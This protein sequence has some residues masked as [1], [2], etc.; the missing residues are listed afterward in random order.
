MKRILVI[1]MGI[2]FL[3]STIFMAI[4]SMRNGTSHWSDVEFPGMAAA[5]L[6]WG[7]VG[8]SV[9][10]GTVIGWAVNAVVYGLIAFAVL[11][12]LRISQIIFARVFS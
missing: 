8:S 10:V 11:G 2:G 4:P 3:I 6:F 12:V 5:Y 9:F 1:A 7:A